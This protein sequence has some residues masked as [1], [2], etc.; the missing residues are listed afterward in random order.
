MDRLEKYA[1]VS[2]GRKDA[3]L[4]LVKKNKLVG[5]VITY[6]RNKSSTNRETV[7]SILGY[8]RKIYNYILVVR[9][10]IWHALC[11]IKGKKNIRYKI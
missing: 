8:D 7:K 5:A 6:L 10:I 3:D 2:C 9:V 1:R 4:T 11:V